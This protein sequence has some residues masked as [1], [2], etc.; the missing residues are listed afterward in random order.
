MESETRKTLVSP[1]SFVVLIEWAVMDT[2]SPS[3]ASYLAGQTLCARV[4]MSEFARLCAF[5]PLLW[6]WLWL[7]KPKV[8]EPPLTQLG[9]L[10]HQLWLQTKW[11]AW[12]L[13]PDTKNCHFEL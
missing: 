7:R 12:T 8:R 10:L 2:S 6:H 13:A 3:L 9:G 4:C 5:A 11:A 1:E